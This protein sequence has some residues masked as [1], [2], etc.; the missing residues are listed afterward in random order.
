MSKEL[1][2]TTNTL[3]NKTLF[4][5]LRNSRARVEETSSGKIYVIIDG[6]RIEA[7]KND[8]FGINKFNP[9]EWLE[10]MVEKYDKQMK[11]NR[12]KINYLEKAEE[13]LNNAIKKVK[14]S[15]SA[16][17]SKYHASKIDQISDNKM[18]AK[19]K[20]LNSE[21][22]ELSFKK[23]GVNNRIHSALLDNF[24]AACDKGKYSNQLSFTN[25]MLNK[26][27]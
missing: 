1:S 16:L 15:I 9:T 8:L 6:V 14:N 22:W 21:K 11:K 4:N 18:R 17:L 13:E 26:L 25:A 24:L 2:Y 20:K 23:T 27:A 19:A 5:S 7:D 12:E 3:N 10:K